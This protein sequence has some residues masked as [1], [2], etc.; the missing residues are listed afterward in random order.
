[1]KL[2]EIMNKAATAVSD[3]F[4]SPAGFDEFLAK[5]QPVHPLPVYLTLAHLE[6]HPG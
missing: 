3:L 6:K 5:N 2:A 4:K 1:M